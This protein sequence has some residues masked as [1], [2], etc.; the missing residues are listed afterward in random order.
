L[1]ERKHYERLWME[2][3]K[4]ALQSIDESKRVHAYFDHEEQVREFV[5][6]VHHNKLVEK[7]SLGWDKLAANEQLASSRKGSDVPSR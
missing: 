4:E 5:H 7:A 6:E 1:L 3:N 2:E